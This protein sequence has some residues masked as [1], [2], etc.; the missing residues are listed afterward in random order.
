MAENIWI[1][2]AVDFDVETPT[3]QSHEERFS[4][5]AVELTLI[6]NRTPMV[7]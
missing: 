6:R 1:G 2:C 5:L 4:P 3:G 7:K